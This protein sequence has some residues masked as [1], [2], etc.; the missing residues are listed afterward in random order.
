MS[1]TT[2]TPATETS[3]TETA[4]TEVQTQT[5]ET[6]PTE[7]SWIDSLDKAIEEGK[8]SVKAE[9]DEASTEAEKDPAEAEKAKEDKPEETTETSEEEAPKNLSPKA[10]EQ[11]KEIKKAKRVAEQRVAELEAK[12]KDA[13]AAPKPD[14]AAVED[15]QKAITERETKIAEYEKE[16]AISR[17]EA[18]TEYKEAVVEPLAAIFGVVDRM[19]K[20]YEL[21]EKKLINILEESDPDKQGDMIDEIASAFKE[22]D[23]VNLYNLADDYSAVMAQRDHLKE[24][25]QVALE[26]RSK[27]TAAAEARKSSEAKANWEKTTKTVWDS[28]K[29]KIPLP[30]EGE[31]LAKAEQDIVAQVTGTDFGA[32][33]DDVKAFAAFSG[34]IIPHL[35]KKDAANK[36]EIASLKQ[37]LQKYQTQTP[38]S[39]AGVSTDTDDNSGDDFL[40]SIEKN[41]RM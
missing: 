13:E 9:G 17:Y 28:L 18:T 22:R 40:T 20:K 2:Q 31:E 16:L 36:A 10:A 8:I 3:A 27:E 38:G 25:A 34:A 39:A 5:T 41:F 6:A 1:D 12:L 29:Q 14:T 11:F 33:T 19:A 21:S 35:V 23:R 15:L 26:A 30:L 32:V 24:Q 37:A 7:S 4:T